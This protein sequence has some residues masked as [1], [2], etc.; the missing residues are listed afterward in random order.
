VAGVSDAEREEAWPRILDAARRDHI[1]VSEHDWRE[2]FRGRQ[3][4]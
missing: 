2:L 4:H 3:G 1:E